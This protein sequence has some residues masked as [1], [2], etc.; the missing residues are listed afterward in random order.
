MK[1][2][3]SQDEPMRVVA[4]KNDGRKWLDELKKL[5]ENLIILEQRVTEIEL[6]RWAMTQSKK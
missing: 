3:K 4:S 2:E 6:N 5:R 1:S